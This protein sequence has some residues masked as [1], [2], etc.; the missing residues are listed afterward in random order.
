MENLKEYTP[1]ELLKM[2]ND[3]ATK[4]DLLKKEII[5]TSYQ[6]EKIEKEIKTKLILLDELEKNYI[7]I[8]ENLKEKNV[9]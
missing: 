4:H 1:T 6:L 9:I 2:L 8:I 7:E 5:S 3:I